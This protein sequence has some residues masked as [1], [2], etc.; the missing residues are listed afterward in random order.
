MGKNSVYCVFYVLL[1]V[2]WF[3]IVL[4]LRIVVVVFVNMVI[5]RRRLLMVL[6]MIVSC[7]L[8]VVGMVKMNLKINVKFKDF[9]G[10]E[11]VN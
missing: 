2:W 8:V 1:D 11:D 3:G 7:V 5:M 10:I 9:Y 6:Y 4:G